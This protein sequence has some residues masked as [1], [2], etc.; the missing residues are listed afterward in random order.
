[1]DHA[2]LMG[3]NK[4]HKSI[5]FAFG[6]VFQRVVVGKPATQSTKQRFYLAIDAEIKR[7][8]LPV[9]LLGL[10]RINWIMVGK[11][12]TVGLSVPVKINGHEQVVLLRNDLAAN[13][14]KKAI[15][16]AATAPV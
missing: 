10:D 5:Q 8:G 7:K 16:P 4:Q 1:M 3:L 2:A 6:S 13:R 14:L 12:N 15:T 11:D 9:E